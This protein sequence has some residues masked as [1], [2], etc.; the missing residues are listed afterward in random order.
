MQ[1]QSQQS[2]VLAW[3]FLKEGSVMRDG[4][5]APADG[6]KLVFDGKPFLCEQGLHA[7]LQP[8]DALFYAPGPI[9]CLVRCEG[10]IVHG[11][12]KIVCTERTIVA[13]IDATDLLR[14]FAR[15]QALKVLHL[16][17]APDIVVQYLQTGEESLRAAAY[18]AA[19]DAVYVE[20][21]ARATMNDVECA[22]TN[23]A[24]YAAMN[25]AVYAT[26]NTAVYDAAHA[27][28]A[29]AAA[30]TADTDMNE[31]DALD[32]AVTEFSTLVEEAFSKHLTLHE[33]GVKVHV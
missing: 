25:A 1:T 2:S 31:L 28:S 5:V 30:S 15:E 16:W 12:D 8:F 21:A 7:S 6:V 9:L 17:N 3:H 14:K 23:D 24:A 32:T 19:D 26:M 27:A 4:K 11:D 20:R 29:S 33:F 18:A 13:R 10:T 22:T